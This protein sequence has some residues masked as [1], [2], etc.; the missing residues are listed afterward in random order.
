MALLRL[1]SQ[2]P[3]FHPD[4]PQHVLE[5][6][7]EV[8]AI[9]RTSLDGRVRVVC[10]FNFTDRDIKV[11]AELLELRL[12]GNSVFRNLLDGASLEIVEGRWGLRPYECAWVTAG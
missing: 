12:P 1:R 3:A 7:D 10:C 11:P 2:C 5:W 6:G 9:Q 8:F 4:A